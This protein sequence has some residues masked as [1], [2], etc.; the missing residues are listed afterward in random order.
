[1]NI[2][3]SAWRRAGHLGQLVVIAIVAAMLAGGGTAVAASSSTPGP[4]TVGSAQ[5]INAGVWGGDIHDNTIPESKLGWDLRQKIAKTGA[6]GKPGPQGE[7]GPKGEPGAKG[8]QGDTGPQGPAGDP[9]SDVFGKG[10]YTK[11]APVTIA[12]IGGSFKANKTKLCEF[13]LPAGT[14]MLT[15]SAFFARTTA[16]A[17]GTR[18]Q[19]ALRKGAT[20]DD[21]GQDYGTILGAEISPSKDRELTGATVKVVAGGTVEVF[22]FG[23]NDDGSSAG[24]GE[25]TAA[26]DIAAVRVG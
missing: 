6:E 5:I 9:A 23:Y 18:P 4:N 20:A 17:P 19:L 10:I 25:I 11:C 24:S 21:F 8:P 16:G 2:I 1:M 22:A 15:T 7:Q 3:R 12:K 14:W 13:D 26:A